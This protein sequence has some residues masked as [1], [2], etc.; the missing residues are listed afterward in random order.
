MIKKI[1]LMLEY[2]TYCIWLYNEKNE[3]IDNDNPPEWDDDKKLTDAFMA[4]SDLYDTF[5]IDNKHEFRYIG[6]KDEKI[7][8]QL[9]K[10]VAHAVKILM[11]K[12]NGKY[13]IVNDIDLLTLD[14]APADDGYKICK[15]G[16]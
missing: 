16:A 4:V 12:N 5:F 7:L 3:I 10:A 15:A 13:E 6:C 2:N 11:E 14:D 1:R 8:Q 9:N